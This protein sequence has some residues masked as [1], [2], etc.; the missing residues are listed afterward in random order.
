METNSSKVLVLCLTPGNLV[1]AKTTVKKSKNKSG[2][3]YVLEDP[4]GIRY[5]PNPEVHPDEDTPY[6]V[7]DLMVLA[8]T[9]VIEIHEDH[10][11]YQHGANW[12][13]IRQYNQ[14]LLARMGPIPDEPDGVKESRLDF[15]IDED[16]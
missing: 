8:D 12:D 2:H 16:E 1:I 6:G 7:V 11:V 3:V 5:T 9:N 10:V 13:I 14:F 4:L 15:I